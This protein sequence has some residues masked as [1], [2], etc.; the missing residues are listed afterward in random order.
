MTSSTLTAKKQST[1]PDIL[2]SGNVTETTYK[3]IEL[4]LIGFASIFITLLWVGVFSTVLQHRQ[5]RFSFLGTGQVASFARDVLCQA[6]G[7]A[8]GALSVGNMTR[9]TVQYQFVALYESSCLT[10]G[11]CTGMLTSISSEVGGVSRAIQM[12]AVSHSRRVVA[13]AENLFAG[14]LIEGGTKTLALFSPQAVYAADVLG[15]KS[16]A[17]EQIVGNVIHGYY[18]Y[19][20]SFTFGAVTALRPELIGRQ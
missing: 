15:E 8:D 13:V 17:P 12:L 3:R 5:V 6:Q 11:T 9:D 10:Q 14:R 18:G 1:S 7:V 4:I 16:V 20:D 2:L 19:V